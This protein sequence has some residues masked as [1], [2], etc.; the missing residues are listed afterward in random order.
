[1]A[2]S[3]IQQAEKLFTELSSP[4]REQVRQDR[5]RLEKQA[6]GQLMNTG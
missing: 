6:A 2:L 3:L 4:M 1:M 5:E